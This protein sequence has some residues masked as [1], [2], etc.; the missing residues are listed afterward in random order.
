VS[1]ASDTAVERIGPRCFAA[2]LHDW[3]SSLVGIHGGYSAAVVVRAMEAAIG[4]PSRALRSV[5]V[6][7][8]A[9]PQAG[10]VEVEVAVER[11]GRSMTTT[12]ARLFQ[13]G[14]L[15]QVAHAVSSGPWPGLA[16]DDHVRPR[17]SDPGDA[18]I[19]VPPG[20]IAHF[21]NAEVRL[22]PAVVPFGGGDEAW[23][24]AWL[25]PIDAEPIDAAWIVA[26][27]DVLP[28]AVFS[29]TTGPVTAASIE[30]VVHMATGQP[31][32]GSGEHVYLSC[33]SPLSSEGFAVE[34]ATMWAPDGR[35]LAVARQTRLAGA[36][37]AGAGGPR[38]WS[39]PV[40]PGEQVPAEPQPRGQQ[41]PARDRSPGDSGQQL[42]EGGGPG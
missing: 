2:E 30:Y 4:D 3:W 17:H 11:S 35:V 5:A 36:Q 25:R 33:Y 42:A 32:L 15:L 10:P 20:G 41:H 14:R 16:Y 34:D 22:D 12:S 28:P 19:F 6:Q 13:Q 26:M 39:V 29:R 27:C 7:F 24:A 21:R 37:P 9:A 8:A 40:H 31:R 23:V 38:P 1:F 18:P